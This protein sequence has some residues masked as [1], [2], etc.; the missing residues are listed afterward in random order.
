ML[1]KLSRMVLANYNETFSLAFIKF[2]A[3]IVYGQEYIWQKREA[4]AIQ[5]HKIR[6][7]FS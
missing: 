3:Y 4:L 2:R 6:E 5:W 1:I 7:R